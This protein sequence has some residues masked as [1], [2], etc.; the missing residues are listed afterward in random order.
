MKSTLFLPKKIKIGYQNRTDTYTKKLAYVI[1]YDNKGMLRKEK[2][3]ESWRDK[4]IEPDEFDNI[5]TEG[6]V[7]NK[8]VGD[9][10]DRWGHRQAYTRVYDPRGFEFEITIE[11]LL[12]ILENT[13]C[14]KGKGLEGEFVYAWDGKELVLIPTC[15][16]DYKDI[17]EYNEILQEKKKFNSKNL[18]PGATY[19]TRNNDEEVYLGRYPVYGTVYVLEE[20]EFPTYAKMINWSEKNNIPCY[21]RNSYTHIYEPRYSEKI[22]QTQKEYWFACK[23]KKSY[24]DDTLIWRV[25]HYKTTSHIIDIVN[26]QSHSEFAELIDLMESNKDYSPYDSSKDEYIIEP[27]EKFKEK[28]K[29]IRYRAMCYVKDSI[30]YFNIS[31]MKNDDKICVDK[32]DGN[33]ATNIRKEKMFPNTPSKYNGVVD[34]IPFTIEE[35]YEKFQPYYKNEYLENGKLWRKLYE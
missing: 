18:I 3:W 7:L 30:G 13:S 2:S 8:K 29:N 11:N 17:V 21:P 28:C 6:F 4:S 20:K 19:L 35:F 24:Y 16:P 26:E 23:S 22:G 1:Y 5:P 12:Y 10:A 15:S 31:L 25:C 33:S 14:I 32:W 9:Y 34:Y 27:F